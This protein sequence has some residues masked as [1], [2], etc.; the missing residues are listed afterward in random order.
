VNALLTLPDAPA[1]RRV[2]PAPL[3]PRTPSP[4]RLIAGI[5][6]QSRV[7]ITGTIRRTGT[8]TVGSSPAYHLT[9]ADGSGELDVLFLGWSSVAGLRPGARVTVEGRAGTHDRR[10]TLWN[11]RYRIE[12]APGS[13]PARQRHPAIR[14]WRGRPVFRVPRQHSYAA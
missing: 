8:T 2:L 5:R 14:A 3:K 13:A 1:R 10:L 4:T 6:P 12:S 9:L 11:P 7:V